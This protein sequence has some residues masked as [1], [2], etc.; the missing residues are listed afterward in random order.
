SIPAVMLADMVEQRFFQINDVMIFKTDTPIRETLAQICFV[1]VAEGVCDQDETGEFSIQILQVH[2]ELAPFRASEQRVT[3]RR[4]A[5][6]GVVDGSLQK[7]ATAGRELER[8]AKL[9]QGFGI[10]RMQVTSHSSES[11]DCAATNKL[12]SCSRPWLAIPD[13][14]STSVLAVGQQCWMIS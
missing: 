9:R 7:P 5:Q 13:R 8:L 4:V 3:A 1:I 2:V 12:S 14:T 6:R 11:Q 10:R